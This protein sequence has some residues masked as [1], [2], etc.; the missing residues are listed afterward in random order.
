MFAAG[1]LA[2]SCL[3]QAPAGSAA[4]MAPIAAPDAQ[5][6]A[7]RAEQERIHSKWNICVDVQM[8]AVEEASALELIPE[9]QSDDQKVVDA[10]W[11]RL[12]GMIR[13]GEAKLL[14]WPMVRMVNAD[15]V[16][17]QSIL[18]QRYPNGI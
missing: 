14:A 12:Q 4:L 17:T 13:A 7:A 15:R 1:A 18:E 6:V 10:A 9:F 11:M 16:E 5:K 8:V 2:G 3:G